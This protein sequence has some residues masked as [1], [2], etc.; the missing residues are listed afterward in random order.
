MK[1]DMKPEYAD[2]AIELLRKAV[3]AGWK[4]AAQM[5]EDTDLDPL[6]GREDFKKLMAELV[7][8]PT[9]KPKK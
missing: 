7:N 1:A 2:R 8:R 6:R 4:D 3:Q 5:A 9:A